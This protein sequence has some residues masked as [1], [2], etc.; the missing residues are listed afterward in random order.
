VLGE[1]LQRW[2]AGDTAGRP[3]E[4]EVQRFEGDT[5]A[6]SRARFEVSRLAGPPSH[7]T[8]PTP[9][10]CGA[11]PGST[12]LRN[13]VMFSWLIPSSAPVA[14]LHGSASFPY[15]SMFFVSIG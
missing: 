3:F 14:R 8:A 5:D 12:V 1:L 15:W 4:D 13:Q 9:V 10:L 7:H 6:C 2:R 11:P